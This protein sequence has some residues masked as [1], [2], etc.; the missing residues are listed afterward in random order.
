MP[1]HDPTV[2]PTHA[3]PPSPGGTSSLLAWSASDKAW[4]YAVSGAVPD[5][6]LAAAAVAAHSSVLIG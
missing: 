5:V 4:E 3:P 2:I 6:S 1:C